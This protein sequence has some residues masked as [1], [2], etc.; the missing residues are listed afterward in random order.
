M[1][2]SSPLL[3]AGLVLASFASAGCLTDLEDD[4]QTDADC[5]P[6]AACV[7]DGVRVCVG[8]DAGSGG[9][10]GVGGTG[11]AG[12]LGGSA[13][14]EAGSG[15]GGTGGVEVEPV[16]VGVT[17]WADGP[18]GVF[19]AEHGR[20]VRELRVTVRLDGGEPIEQVLN[21]PPVDGYPLV[22]RQ[23]GDGYE[24]LVPLEIAAGTTPGLQIDVA[25]WAPKQKGTLTRLASGSTSITIDTEAPEA[26]LELTA[27]AAF[28]FDSDAT[29]DWTDCAPE[30]A[31]VYPGAVDVCDD[32]DTDCNPAGTC[33]VQL[34]AGQS[35]RDISC[36][37]GTCLATTDGEGMA[38]GGLVKLTADAPPVVY[39]ETTLVSPLGIALH[40]S[41]ES[42]FIFDAAQ[43]AIGVFDWNGAATSA[44]VAP[45]TSQSGML[46]ISRF[47]NSAF[48]PFA[49][50]PGGDF[51]NPA[52]ATGSSRT[53]ECNGT[54]SSCQ[55]IDFSSLS[56]GTSRLASTVAPIALAI[57]QTGSLSNPQI[58]VA[59]ED[60]KRIVIAQVDRIAFSMP[61]GSSGL[62]AVLPNSTPTV[63]TLSEDQTKLY[64]FG[65]FSSTAEGAVIT[66][67]SRRSDHGAPQSLE[68]P[69]GLCVTG[70][71]ATS[72]ALLLADGCT[73]SLWTIPLVEG[74][75]TDAEHAEKQALPGCSAP[76]R[77]GVI[78]SEQYVVGCRN[79]SSLVV[80]GRD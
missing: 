8:G 15:G 44:S 49:A 72:S 20:D 67:A 65:T 47:G 74:G 12:G 76:S 57:R 31:T 69:A 71:H 19:L 23:A 56:D 27:D 60:E 3:I 11:G 22:S 66:T 61:S 25:A 58:Y 18:L 46:A 32:V 33:V 4:C 39:T 16:D 7:L 54:L 13:G 9:G 1:R 41:S 36:A 50:V 21:D 75:L 48:A 70:A 55:A 30:D 38:A 59:F 64:A 34:P 52:D 62:M 28:D 45:T 68:L 10:G 78:A 26:E 77:L 5:G 40:P 51:F 37:S 29:N 17:V 42:A 80:V 43:S 24:F 35:V 14:G 6:G 2:R 63:L 73:P 79:E 53:I